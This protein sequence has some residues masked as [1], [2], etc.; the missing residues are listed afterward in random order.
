LYSNLT[1]RFQVGW[2]SF[3]LSLTVPDR[4]SPLKSHINLLPPSL[5]CGGNRQLLRRERIGQVKL[6]LGY[7]SAI[8]LFDGELR[9][10]S[11][12]PQFG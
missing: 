9:R 4:R 10:E 12:V 2:S 8:V 3:F 6:N 5:S 7:A 1:S 11:A